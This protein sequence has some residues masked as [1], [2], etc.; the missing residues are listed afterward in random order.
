[1]DKYS[2]R[3]LTE[4]SL[5]EQKS[6]LVDIVWSLAKISRG[7]NEEKALELGINNMKGEPERIFQ[8]CRRDKSSTIQTI[9]EKKHSKMMFAVCLK[10]RIRSDLSQI[11]LNS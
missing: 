2:I 8:I 4:M 11:L 9:I 1:M 6:K 5:T 10:L 3:K 7:Q